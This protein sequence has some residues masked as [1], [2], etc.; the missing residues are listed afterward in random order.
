MRYLIR[1]KTKRE[2]IPALGE[3]EKKGEA[4][5]VMREHSNREWWE[6]GD[7]FCRLDRIIAEVATTLFP[8]LLSPYTDY[9]RRLM[10]ALNHSRPS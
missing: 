2:E 7:D 3:D 8:N 1:Y 6:N 4:W 9:T 5:E 10:L